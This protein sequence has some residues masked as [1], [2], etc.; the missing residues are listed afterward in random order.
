MPFGLKNAAQAFQRFT[1]AVC[2]GVQAGLVYIDDILV[3]SPHEASHKLHLSQLFEQLWD[4]GLVINVAK[5]Q[6]SLSSIDFLVHHIM[7]NSK[8]QL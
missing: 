1:D 4:H 6:F 8:P 2:R 7:Q 3:T 5:S